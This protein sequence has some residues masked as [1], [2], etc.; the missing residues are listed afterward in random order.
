MDVEWIKKQIQDGQY[1]WSL[2]AD[3]ERRNDL[4]DIVD[5]ETAI[6]NG[7]I[8]EDYSTDPRGQ[9]CLVVGESTKG[10]IHIVCGKNK[11]NNLII[12]TVYKPALPKWLNSMER[13]KL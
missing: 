11:N 13:R 12:I 7:R 5:V 4:F 2:H 1:Y 9:S 3:E 6:C 10:P 8:L